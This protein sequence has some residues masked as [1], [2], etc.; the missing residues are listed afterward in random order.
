MNKNV[1]V[2]G[3]DGYIGTA[4]IQRLLKEGYKVITVDNLFRRKQAI[5]AVRTVSYKDKEKHLRKLGD[6]FE[7]YQFDFALEPE[8]LGEIL[9]E[10][11]PDTIVNL[12]HIPSA[13][14]SMKSMNDASYTL[15]NN[16]IG[17]NHLLWQVKEHCPN[18]HLI[19]LGT[20]GE[21]DHYCNIPIEEGYFSIEHKERQ[22]NELIFPRR[23]GSIYHVSKTASTY[24]IDFCCRAWGLRCT[25]I[26]QAVV[27]GAYTDEIHKT[28]LK[29]R[30]DADAD[31]GGTV[32]NRFVVQAAMGYPL[33]IYGEGKHQRGFLSLNDSIQALMIAVTN[34]PETGKSR[35]W[36]QLS[37]WHSMEDIAEM[38]K[39]VGE[40][41][42]LQVKKTY[43]PS[44]R[45][46][47][48]GEHFYEYVTDILP[49]LGYKPTRTIEEEIEYTIDAVDRSTFEEIK[50]HLDPKV[51]WR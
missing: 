36:N 41:K 4:L 46:E 5:S 47:Y 6:V 1:L 2:L 12:A 3:G 16:V 49:S 24:L 15:A 17:T 50:E 14:Y 9:K 42:G 27:F 29:T 18:T 8:R 19:M 23:P 31:Y 20:T 11:Q 32:I 7:A 40:K 34:P 33:T 38:V 28:N 22:S 13:P 51:N 21:Y 37:E 10:F 35:V 25:D 44:P 39:K 48:T 26:M 43:I 30:L 45:S